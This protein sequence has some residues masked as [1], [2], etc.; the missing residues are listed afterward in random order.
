MEKEEITKA[1]KPAKAV[2]PKRPKSDPDDERYSGG[3][4]A[5]QVEALWKACGKERVKGLSGFRRMT[6]RQI[7]EA[8]KD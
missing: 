5:E 4:T 8:L 1:E 3:A 2:E 6:I 7:R